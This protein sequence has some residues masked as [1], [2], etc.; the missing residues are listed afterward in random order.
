MSE[1]PVY[2]RE[3]LEAMTRDEVYAIATDLNI[4]GR[5]NMTKAQLID[6]ILTTQE[7]GV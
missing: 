2:D 3:Q 6:A 1:E 7:G 5:S 4:S